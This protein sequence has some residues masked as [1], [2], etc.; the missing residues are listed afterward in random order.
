[1]LEAILFDPAFDTQD[2]KAAID[3]ARIQPPDHPR[4]QALLFA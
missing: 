1:M 3:G 4:P 2:L